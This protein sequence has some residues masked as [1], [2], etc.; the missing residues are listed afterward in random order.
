MYT[1]KAQNWIDSGHDDDRPVRKTI[2]EETFATLDDAII[3]YTE[4][5]A[6]YAPDEPD[7]DSEYRNLESLYHMVSITYKDFEFCSTY[8]GWGF[9]P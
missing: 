4:L 1:V 9:S 7:I 2:I 5:Q 3:R 6:K 8:Y